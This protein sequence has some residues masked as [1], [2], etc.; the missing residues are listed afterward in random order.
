M[1]VTVVPI[2]VTDMTDIAR[3][4]RAMADSVEKSP[5]KN[6]SCILVLGH[7]TQNVSVYGWGYRCSGLEVQGWLARAAS[8]VAG[9]VERF[10][11]ARG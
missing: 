6:L 9:N 5:E 1:S 2:P 8:W 11:G 10:A 4:L 3:Q 7:D